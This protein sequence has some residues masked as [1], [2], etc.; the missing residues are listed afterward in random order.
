MLTTPRGERAVVDRGRRA[1][2]PLLLALVAY[3]HLKT[4][5]FHWRCPIARITH[6]PCPTCGLSRATQSLLTG[7]FHYAL[8]SQPLVLVVA[9][10]LAVLVTLELGTYVWT[11]ALGTWARKMPFRIGIIVLAIALF[12][13]WIARF[14]GYFGGPVPVE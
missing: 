4:D 6:H 5:T 7:D 8:V 9:P 3:A 12:V 13:M 1:L 10:F 11:G 14:F 2:V